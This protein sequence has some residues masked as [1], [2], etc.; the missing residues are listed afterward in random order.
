[1]AFE[2]FHYGAAFGDCLVGEGAEQL[3][4]RILASLN[5]VNQ[6]MYE[7]RN[8]TYGTRMGAQSSMNHDLHD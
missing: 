5:A 1:M 8:R 6:T 4:L 7:V 3:V 2:G